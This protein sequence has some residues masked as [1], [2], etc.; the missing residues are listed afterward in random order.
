MRSARA[1]GSSPPPVF[2]AT[3]P[4][5]RVCVSQE[6]NGPCQRHSDDAAEVGSRE[7]AHGRCQDSARSIKPSDRSA[8][9]YTPGLLMWLVYL[10]ALVVGG[11][12]LL[13]QAISGGHDTVDAGHSL[14]RP[15]P[16]RGPGP[17]VAPLRIYGLFTFGFVGRGP[18]HPGHRRARGRLCCWPLASGVAAALAAGFTFAR[19]GSADASGRGLAASRRGAARRACCCRAAPDRPGKIRLD[20]GGQQVDMK[21]TSGGAADS[22]RRR[23][24]G[25][26][27]AWRTWRVSRHRSATG[28]TS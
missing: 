24:G 6:K 27:G 23:G 17:P 13:V 18:A 26:R 16:R 19:L 22:G 20:L 14:G 12:L 15:A 4:P 8:F 7:Q 9:R 28:G 11:G 25:G 1:M 2:D 10:L 5:F 21:A 3:G